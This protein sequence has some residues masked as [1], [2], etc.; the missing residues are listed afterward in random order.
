MC[1]SDGFRPHVWLQ[2]IADALPGS[3]VIKAHLLATK[4]DMPCDCWA[5]MQKVGLVAHAYRD[6][7]DVFTSLY[8]YERGFMRRRGRANVSYSSLEE[9]AASHK[10]RERVAKSWAYATVG[11]AG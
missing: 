11:Q 5:W 9:F 1:A 8:F 4:E 2:V 3:V 10:Q 7:R 6:V